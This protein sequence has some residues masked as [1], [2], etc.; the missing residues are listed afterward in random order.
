MPPAARNTD[1]AMLC[2][3]LMAAARILCVVGARPNFMKMAPIVRALARNPERFDPILVHTGQHYDQ[4]M[5]KVFFDELQMPR[6]EVDLNVGSGSHAVQ[7]AGIMTAFEPVIVDRR[8][9]LVIVVGDVNSTI[10]C[11][12]VAAKIG[13]RV[14]HVEAGL[15]SFDHTMPEEINR[16]LTDRISQLLFTTEESARDNLLR[17]GIEED[18]IYFVGNVMIDTLLAHRERARALDAPSTYGLS[19]PFGLVTLHRPANVDDSAA[20]AGLFSA[21]EIIAADMPLVFPVHPR[22]RTSLMAS[23]QAQRL[24]A[25]GRLKLLE[26]LG[27]LAFIGLLQA[28][29]VVFTDSGGIQEETTILGIPCLT[30]RNNT[31]RPSTVT[32]GTNVI[33]GT[34]PEGVLKAWR[35]MKTAGPERRTPP[36]WDGNAAARIAEV[37]DRVL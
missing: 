34:S 36:L 10:A 13:V 2:F 25:S 35:E 22:T 28:S 23:A 33:A 14:A 18:R 3:A 1:I 11:A 16:L 17:E 19:G 5:S 6:P 30:L 26:P 24:V 37:L 15:R 4:A 21:F 32:H 27:Y 20:F 29:S 9:D 7:T 8:P 12:L 31:E